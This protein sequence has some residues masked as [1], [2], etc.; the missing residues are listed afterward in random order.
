M[1]QVDKEKETFVFD[2]LKH[3]AD[4]LEISE[5]HWDF[6]GLYETMGILK[7]SYEQIIPLEYRRDVKLIL[8]KPYL[9][10][11]STDWNPGL[12]GWKYIPKKEKK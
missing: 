6:E 1:T 11:L 5:I 2:P 4:S 7:E 8:R 9:P 3:Y 12:V 10:V